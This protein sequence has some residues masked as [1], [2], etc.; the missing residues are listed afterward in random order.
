M[1]CFLFRISLLNKYKCYVFWWLKHIVALV[2]LS[3]AL[4]VVDQTIVYLGGCL[5]VICGL[6]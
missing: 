6:M 5:Q 1:L 4:Y 3:G 2:Q